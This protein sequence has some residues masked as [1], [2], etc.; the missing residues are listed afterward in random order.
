MYSTCKYMAKATHFILYKHRLSAN[1]TALKYVM[2]FIKF[3]FYLA[4]KRDQTM[5]V[6]SCLLHILFNIL[7]TQ[8]QNNCAGA[9]FHTRGNGYDGNQRQKGG[10]LKFRGFIVFSRGQGLDETA[11]GFTWKT[12]PK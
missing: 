5:V 11:K 10:H 8:R 12:A 4:F 6:V 1:C 9:H 2:Q 3:S 7:P